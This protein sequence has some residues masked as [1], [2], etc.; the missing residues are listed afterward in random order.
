MPRRNRLFPLILS[1]VTLAVA[2]VC[3]ADGDQSTSAAGVDIH[4]EGGTLAEFA[5]LLR[6]A[7]PSYNIILQGEA[8]DFPVQALDLHQVSIPGCVWVL[9]TMRTEVNGSTRRL[10]SDS[11]LEASGSKIIVIG[12]ESRTRQVNPRGS[13]VPKQIDLDEYHI[14]VMSVGQLLASGITS[15]MIMDNIA[16][17]EE[18]GVPIGSK[19]A[20]VRID[21]KTGVLMVRATALQIDMVEE[22]LGSLESSRIFIEDMNDNADAAKAT[23]P[24]PPP[25]LPTSS[26]RNSSEVKLYTEAELKALTTIEIRNHLPQ[27]SKARKLVRG[28]DVLSDKLKNQFD[29]LMEELKGRR[30]D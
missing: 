10:S 15:K 27:V 29:L 28:D 24:P 6:Q 5:D 23:P 16:M 13:R 2:P 9:D 19:K 4:F 30:D 8:A 22:L 14:E 26:A 1:T 3:L 18:L 20:E 12:Q 11:Y 7:D 17:L 25:P 21:T